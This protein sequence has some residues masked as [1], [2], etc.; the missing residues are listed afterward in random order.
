MLGPKLRQAC[1]EAFKGALLQACDSTAFHSPG[2][3]CT[4]FY[5]ESEIELI[6]GE[7]VKAIV[8]IIPDPP[9]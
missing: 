5:L 3:S 6:M 9:R 7:R 2:P 8:R 1:I 4:R